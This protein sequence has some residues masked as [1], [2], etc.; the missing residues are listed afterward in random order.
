MRE[1]TSYM[2]MLSAGVRTTAKMTLTSAGYNVDDDKPACSRFEYM[3]IN[4]IPLYTDYS[5]ALR[6]TTLVHASDLYY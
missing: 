6:P 5:W 3:A 2:N 1:R 4:A